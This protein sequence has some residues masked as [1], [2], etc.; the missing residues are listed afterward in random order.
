[1]SWHHKLRVFFPSGPR[2]N[3]LYPSCLCP[4]YTLCGAFISIPANSLQLKR[5]R[6]YIISA[7]MKLHIMHFHF[8]YILVAF[9]TVTV[10]SSV[11]GC[12]R[13]GGTFSLH[14][15][16]RRECGEDAPR[17]YRDGM[18]GGQLY[19]WRVLATCWDNS[20]NIRRR[21]NENSCCFSHLPVLK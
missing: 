10:H 17:L 1:M 14:L 15:Q 4:S 9:W 8:N 2:T 18:K 12:K 20:V 5:K 11:G 19:T 3:M 6:R 21:W 16:G 7:I 13:F